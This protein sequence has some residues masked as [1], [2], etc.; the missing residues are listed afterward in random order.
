MVHLLRAVAITLVC[1]SMSCSECKENADCPAGNICF[2]RECRAFS[3]Q[4]GCAGDGDCDP[5]TRCRSNSC[6]RVEVACE[7][8]D[9]CR[10][11]ETCTNNR[12]VNE[13]LSCESDRDC[14]LGVVCELNECTEGCDS[15]FDCDD[16]ALC[17][18]NRCQIFDC[19]S[20]DDCVRGECVDETC[21]E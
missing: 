13:A 20:S 5:G 9:T 14:D 2:A 4:I 3:G 11:G 19:F 1:F 16:D 12:C 7:A 21:R 18:E 6:V 10:G 8:T 15:D 17:E